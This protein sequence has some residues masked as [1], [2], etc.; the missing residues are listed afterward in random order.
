M[1][2][3]IDDLKA[4]CFSDDNI[5]MTQHLVIRCRER[6]IRFDD[7]KNSIL[8]GEI[9]EQYPTDFP[10]PSCLVIGITIKSLYLHVVT[11]IGD[12]KIWIITAYFPSVDKWES[13]FKTRKVVK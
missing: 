9:I 6:N 10:Y 8:S 2:I 1:S 4:L 7:I 5:I 12:N 13:D 11:G 3:S